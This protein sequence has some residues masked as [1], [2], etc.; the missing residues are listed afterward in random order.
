MCI[1]KRFAY[2]V[3]QRVIHDLHRQRHLRTA[4]HVDALFQSLT[5]T[6]A[7]FIIRFLIIDVIACQLDH[8]NSN[9]L[10]KRDGFA[11]DLQPLVANHIVFTTEWKTT[12]GTQAH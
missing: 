6:T 7:S 10:R 3:H 5:K 2:G 1:A 4:G 8:S 11:H 12:M 9:I